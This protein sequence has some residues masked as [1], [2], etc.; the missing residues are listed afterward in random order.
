[1]NAESQSCLESNNYMCGGSIQCI[2]VSY[3]V[4]GVKA[5]SISSRPQSAGPE[6]K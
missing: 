2:T 5:T 6:K 3:L 4:L 1:M